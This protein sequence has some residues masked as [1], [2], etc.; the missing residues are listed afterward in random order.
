[1]AAPQSFASDISTEMLAAAR[2]GRQV[3]SR[4]LFRR[5]VAVSQVLADLFTCATGTFAA[6]FLHPS[7]HIGRQN[8]YPV[9][10]VAGV[11]ITA[12]LLMVLLLRRSGAYRGVGSLL[13][14]RETEHALRIPAQALLLLLPFSFLLNLK[15]SYGAF[16]TALVLLPPLL[17]FE[18]QMFFS[19]VRKLY[20]R[21][22]GVDRVVVYAAGD[23]AKRIVST[24]LYSPGLGLRPV[25]V[26]NDDPARAGER[27][28]EMGYRRHLSVT[29]QCGPVTPAMLKAYQCNVLIVAAPNLGSEKLTAAEH[30]AKQAGPGIRFLLDPPDAE[31]PRTPSIDVDGMLRPS[32]V[33][34][35]ALFH[36]AAAKRTTDVIVSSLLLLLLAPLLVLIALLIS[37]DSPGPALFV[38]KR[39]GRQGKLFDMYKFRSMHTTARPYDFSPTRS[40]DPRITTIGRFLRRASFDE[41]P[42]LINVLLGNMTLVGPRPEMPFIVRR[43]NS[44]QRRRLQAIPGITGLWQLSADRAFPIHENIQYDLGYIQNRTFFMDIAIL[45][46]TLFRAMRGGV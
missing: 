10:A 13:Q 33:D 30:A 21:E 27:I 4:A 37:L 43:Y 25:A 29:V 7:L 39:V 22:Y 35:I 5:V 42:Q 19:I 11:G 44:S 32:A 23:A 36:Y 20:I 16:L 38:Q 24:L 26:I 41:L 17:I 6:Y 18:K 3:I 34:P 31:Q 40:S 14:I 46:H 12:G 8:P 1:M 15:V 2:E 28:F 9:W 45:L